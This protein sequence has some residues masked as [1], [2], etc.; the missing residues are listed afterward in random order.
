MPEYV[1]RK[2]MILFGD[3]NVGT[4]MDEMSP[5]KVGELELKKY[6]ILP[7]DDLKDAYP[8]LKKPGVLNVNTPLGPCIWREY[9]TMW[10]TDR[11]PSRKNAIA[12]IDCTFEGGRTVYTN[13]YKILKDKIREM[14]THL[15]AKEFKILELEGEL[16][17][18]YQ[19]ILEF[20]RQL[21]DIHQEIRGEQYGG[22]EEAKEKKSEKT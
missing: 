14:E 20:A 8:F 13:K 10:I 9:P 16:K 5:H 1:E 4:V 17:T 11:N 21:A 7:S 19:S 6:L 15:D 12:R 18:S 22:S 3:D 2:K